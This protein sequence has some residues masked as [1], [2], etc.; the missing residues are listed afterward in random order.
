MTRNRIRCP[1]CSHAFKSEQ[2]VLAH[3]NQPVSGCLQRYEEMLRV[4]GAC[5]ENQV[6]EEHG[7]DIPTMDYDSAPLAGDSIP[8]DREE[9]MEIDTLSGIH[10]YIYH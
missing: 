5:H 7:T 8:S 1:R 6:I 10:F 4:Y 2:A 3:M 9:L